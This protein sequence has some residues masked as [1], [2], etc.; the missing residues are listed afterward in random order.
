MIAFV[1]AVAVAA[2]PALGQGPPTIDPGMTQAQVVAKLGEPLST[3]T[4][5]GH[6]YLL[7]K[8]G[9]ERSCGMSDLVV[10]DSDKVVDAIFRSNA[11]RYSGTSSSPR[12]I[13]A[14][15]LQKGPEPVDIATAD[16]AEKPAKAAKPAKLAKLAKVAPPKVEGIDKAVQPAKVVKPA[17]AA[18]PATVV[19]VEKVDKAEKVKVENGETAPSK[20][21]PEKIPAPV[22]VA[23][24]APAPAAPPKLPEV[25]RPAQTPKK[26]TAK[27]SD[28]AIKPD[29]NKKPKS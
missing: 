15:D 16:K 6:T 19:R 25:F 28:A 2:S 29:P 1:L 21:A 26:D 11:R 8:N 14:A 10:L 22:P 5:D 18:K 7:Y 17:K 27:K 24:P 4:Y 13:L 9:C 20:P 12:M 23:A 3:R